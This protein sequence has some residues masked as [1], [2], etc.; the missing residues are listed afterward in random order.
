MTLS[1]PVVSASSGGSALLAGR[2]LSLTSADWPGA[3]V[4]LDQAVHLV[5]VLA[6]FTLAAS[7]T[8]WAPI[9]SLGYGVMAGLPNSSWVLVSFSQKSSSGDRPS[10]PEPAIH[11]RSPTRGC[12]TLTVAWSFA[13]RR[14]LGEFSSHDQVLRNQAVGST[15]RVAWS[16]PPSV[17]LLP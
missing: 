8:T 15:S 12:S 5:A 6:G 7:L 9:P 16:R 17:T 4:S 13:A 3:T 2:S 1:K 14:G 11:S 10:G